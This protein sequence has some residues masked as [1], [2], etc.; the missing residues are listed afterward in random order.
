VFTFV[1]EGMEETKDIS[2]SDQQVCALMRDFM[3]ERAGTRLH[4]H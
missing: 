4:L 1:L 3:I 2:L